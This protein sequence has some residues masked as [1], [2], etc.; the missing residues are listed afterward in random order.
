MSN[1]V[2]LNTV[3]LVVA[4]GKLGNQKIN[5]NLGNFREDG[6]D[7]ASFRIKKDQDLKVRTFV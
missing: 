7:F 4:T 5:A 6:Q 3:F 1:T 2:Q